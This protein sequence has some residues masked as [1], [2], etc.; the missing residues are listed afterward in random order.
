VE[1][2]LG[3]VSTITCGDLDGYSFVTSI[4]VQTNKVLDEIY[5]L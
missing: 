5:F 1:W 3:R 2:K 4:F